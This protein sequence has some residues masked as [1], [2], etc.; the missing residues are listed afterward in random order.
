[1]LIQQINYLYGATTRAD[2]HPGDDALDRYE[3]L[4]AEMDGV[5]ESLERLSRLVSEE[6][7]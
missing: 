4:R 2:Q 1:M 7:R 3:E 6:D 5:I